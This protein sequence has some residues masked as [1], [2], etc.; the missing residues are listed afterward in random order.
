MKI[1]MNGVEMAQRLKHAPKTST[2]PVI[3]MSSYLEEFSKRSL[4][5]AGFAACIVKPINT[6]TLTRQ[7]TE[8][9]AQG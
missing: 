9:L 4:R 8:A 3:A 1:L 2:I 6:R 5:A 7:V